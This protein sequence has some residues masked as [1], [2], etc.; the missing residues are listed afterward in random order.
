MAI[1]GSNLTRATQAG[2]HR[3]CGVAVFVL[4]A[5]LAW[6]ESPATTPDSRVGS[7]PD[8]GV[9]PYSKLSNEQLGTLAGTF[10]DLDRDQRRWF[11]T[12]VRK[13]M[14]AKGEGPRIQ[15]DQDDRFGRVVRRVR[16]NDSEP[17]ETQNPVARSPADEESAKPTK[18]YGTGVQSQGEE[19][20]DAPTPTRQ[21][22]DPSKPSE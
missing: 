17:R 7:G 14:S 2:A 16:H 22:E 18:V 5:I 19:T 13:R 9:N 8:A 10:E 12:E 1:G 21:S 11:L 3:T 15:V 20:A 4:A 6:G